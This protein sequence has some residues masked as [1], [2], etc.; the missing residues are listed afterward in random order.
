M[1]PGVESH[2]DHILPRAEFK[3]LKGY[4]SLNP[5]QKAALLKDPRNFQPLNASMNCSKGCKVVDG[6]L[7]QW[8]EYKGRPLNA[9]Y[10]E[11]LQNEQRE[12]RFYFEQK[13]EGLSNDR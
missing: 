2:R 1:P 10:K 13:I 8:D 9:A 3:N 6:S 12:L 4:D 7:G 5:A 11:W